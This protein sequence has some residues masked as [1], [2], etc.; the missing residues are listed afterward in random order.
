M[1]T[2]VIALLS[3][4]IASAQDTIPD[5]TRLRVRLDQTIS[6]GSADQG[7]T[8]ELSVTEP[9]KVGDQV[10]IAE[11]ARVTGTVIM[12]QEKRHMGRAGKLDFSIDRVRANDGEWIP[13]RYTLHKTSG[14]S[15]AVSTG[16][17]TAGAAVLFWPAA[18]AFLLIKGKDVNI[19][20]GMVL[21]AFT[22]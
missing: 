11:G 16:V 3:V 22:D 21:D 18:P 19:T 6:S 4:A 15:H 1:K 10:V 17:L 2:L 12:A 9:V 5:G 7:Q 20:K 8:V 13:L 14:G